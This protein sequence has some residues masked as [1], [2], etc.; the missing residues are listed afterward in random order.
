MK[1]IVEPKQNTEYKPK[2]PDGFSDVTEFNR[3]E[4]CRIF[5][6]GVPDEYLL[7]DNSQTE[8]IIVN[9]SPSRFFMAPGVVYHGSM[10]PLFKDKF[11]SVVVISYLGSKKSVI[12]TNKTYTL[13]WK[14]NANEMVKNYFT[15]HIKDV[16][17]TFQL[18]DPK[19]YKSNC[20][21]IYHVLEQAY[22]RM[23]SWTSVWARRVVKDYRKISQGR[24]GEIGMGKKVVNS[25]GNVEIVDKKVINDKAILS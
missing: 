12:L 16:L 10:S 13:M 24:T 3:L 6:T 20:R 15:Y 14:P 18:D 8:N 22:D 19:G 23:T 25:K 4:K 7:V 17:K 9:G 1:P 21:N 11:A 2:A 5:P